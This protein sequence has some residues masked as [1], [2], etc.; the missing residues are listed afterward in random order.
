MVYWIEV[1]GTTVFHVEDFAKGIVYTNITQPG[2]I[3]VNLQGTLT[4]VT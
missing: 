4:K 1:D 2:G 3:F